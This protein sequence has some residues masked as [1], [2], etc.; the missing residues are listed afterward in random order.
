MAK[1]IVGIQGDAGSTNERACKLFA[2]KFGWEDLEIQYLISTENVLRALEAGKIDYGTFAWGSSRSGLV[3][4]TQIA[5]GKF[6]FQKIDEKTLKLDHALLR[7]ASIDLNKPVKVYS[8]P[9]ALREHEPFLVKEFDKVELI[10]EIDTAV[11]ASKLHDNAYPE[12]SLVIAPI[13]CAE[14]YKLDV[15]MSDLP[16]NNGYFVNIYLVQKT[17]K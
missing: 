17:S 2:E 6:N 5:V 9:H 11:A 4:E 13:S 14:I 7:N 16:T 15:H 1:I 10:E 12:N 8:H 3:R